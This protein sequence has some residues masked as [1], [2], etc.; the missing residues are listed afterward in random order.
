[1]LAEAEAV[2]AEAEVDA[3][4]GGVGVLEGAC[5]DLGRAASYSGLP[6]DS[7]GGL[8]AG[9]GVLRRFCAPD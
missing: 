2:E 1:M 3:D 5:L 4:I 6:L 8:A 9:F 7:A